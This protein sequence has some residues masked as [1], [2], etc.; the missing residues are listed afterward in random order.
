M[1]PFTTLEKMTT[2][3]EKYINVTT[4]LEIQIVHEYTSNVLVRLMGAFRYLYRTIFIIG[5][6]ETK[7]QINHLKGMIK[8][9]FGKQNNMY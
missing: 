7:Y 9:A 4:G 6:T 5:I 1:F 3:D 2:V 8:H